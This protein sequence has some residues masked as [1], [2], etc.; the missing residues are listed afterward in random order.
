MTKRYNAD[1]EKKRA[2]R[3]KP[4]KDLKTKFELNKTKRELEDLKKKME[5]MTESK[6]ASIRKQLVKIALSSKK[7]IKDLILPMI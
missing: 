5:S 7:E 3:L 2:E 6:K 4:I 1:Q